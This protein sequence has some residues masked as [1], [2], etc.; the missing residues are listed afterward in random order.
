VNIEAFVEVEQNETY[1]LKFAICDAS[2]GALDSGIILEANSF[3]G[4]FLSVFD[5]NRPE[6]LKLYP[7]PSTDQV[8]I[9]I[10]STYIGQNLS[11]RI[12]DLQGRVVNETNISA[13]GTVELEAGQL[14][15]GLYLVETSTNGKVF[16]LSKLLRD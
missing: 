8:Y 11:L 2:D 4:K 13:T 5:Q 9:E 6:Q 3:E 1:H 7:N 10:P 15:K 12:L 16:G 14:E